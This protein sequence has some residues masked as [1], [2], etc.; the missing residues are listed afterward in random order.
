MRESVLAQVE[1]GDGCKGIAAAAV[2][3]TGYYSF[4]FIAGY[5]PAI[6]FPSTHDTNVPYRLG[7]GGA[8]SGYLQAMLN[9]TTGNATYP[10]AAHAVALALASAADSGTIV[11]AG[12]IY[13]WLL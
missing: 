3:N 5:C 12:L 1:A 13:G 10:K 7:T 6:R 9:A 4:A 8:G 11:D 2:S